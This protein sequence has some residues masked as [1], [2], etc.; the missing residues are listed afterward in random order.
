[1][2]AKAPSPGFDTPSELRGAGRLAGRGALFA[3]VAQGVTAS[4]SIL[5]TIVV[6]RLL[7]PAEYGIV[8]MVTPVTGF[9]LIFQ[10]LGLGQAVVQTPSL[11]ERQLSTIF[12]INLMASALTAGAILAISPLVA[13]FY[14]NVSAGLLTAALAIN[15]FLS[16]LVIQHLALLNRRLKY[17]T[18]A[19]IDI[20]RIAAIFGATLLAAYVL[21]TYWAIWLGMLAGL[22][23]N[24]VAAW[25]VEPWR[26]T[27]VFAFR[28]ARPMVKFGVHVTGFTLLNFLTRN[29][30]NVLVAR[31]WGVSAAGLYDRSYKL[32]MFPIQNINAP[33]G[34]VM[35][36]LLSRLSTHDARY[37]RAY[38]TALRAISFATVPG[39]MVAAASSDWLVPF[40]LGAQWSEATPIFFW[41]S[42]AALPQ[43]SSNAAGWLFLSRGRGA[44]LLKWGL[45]ASAVIIPAFIVGLPWG[46]V[47]VAR[48]YCVAQAVLAVC[49]YAFSVRGTPVRAT[50]FYAALL[51]CLGGGGV[52]WILSAQFPE[53]VHPL[54]TLMALL[55]VAYLCSL[56]F[57]ATTAEGRI[58]VRSCFTALMEVLSRR[59][60]PP[61][62]QH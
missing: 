31:A 8:A 5:S 30:D 3:A 2:T 32:M 10:N 42:L 20:V 28:E 36:P 38:V 61:V 59:K 33:L 57:Q 39:I 40:L 51:P 11:S 12:W 46:A 24:L 35:L 1:V 50:D 13:L 44:A 22:L 49:L 16:G 34:R 41:L 53:P 26:P 7:S 29:L 23:V 62:G 52:A 43:P 17:A 25:L 60:Q 54:R 6:A 58:A 45:L 47:G 19:V 21:R 9:I 48:A 14:G 37:R 55:V 15:A 27:R 4:L 18:I 56:A